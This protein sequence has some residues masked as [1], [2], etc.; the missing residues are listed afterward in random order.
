MTTAQNIQTGIAMAAAAGAALAPLGGPKLILAEQLLT[1]GLA[2][3]ADYQAKKVAGALTMD[4]L[5]AA[6]AQT[7]ADLDAFAKTVAALPE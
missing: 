6:A 5:R 2:F 4:D 3:W 1:Q 7:G